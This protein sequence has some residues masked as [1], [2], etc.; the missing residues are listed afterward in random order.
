MKNILVPSLLVFALAACN[1]PAEPPAT[2]HE[3]EEP[4]SSEPTSHSLGAALETPPTLA[5][6]ASSAAI[7][8][9]GDDPA[10][11]LVLGATG[12]GGIEI[13]SLAGERLGT[14]A[15]RKA[16]LVDVHYNFPLSGQPRTLVVAFDP[17]T[18]EIV[19][20]TPG[21]DGNSLQLIAGE[22]IVTGTELEGLCLYRSP[23][24]GNFYAF[25][26]G[27]GYLQQW[28]L[29]ERDGAVAGRLIRNVPAGLG[30]AYCVVD[31]RS[32]TL[33]YSQE[34]VGVWRMNAEPESEAVPMAVDVANPFGRFE[35]DIKGISLYEQAD[36]SS[37]LLVSN[38]D[39]GLV[40]VYLGPDFE[41][42]GAF[43]IASGAIDGVEE[44]ENLGVAS[45]VRTSEFPGGVVIAV[46]EANEEG[47]SNFKLL[48]WQAIAD[49]HGLAV[50]AA[51]DPTQAT[52]PTATTVTASVETQPVAGFG[53]AADDPAIWVHP[54]QPEL[55]LII[56]TQKQRGLNIYAMDGSL[57]QT[58][59]DGRINNVDL[60]YG[61][62]LGDGQVDVITATNRT[63]ET[64]GIYAVDPETRNIYN[65][66]DGD[67]ATDM[68]DPYGLCMYRSAQTGAYYV[69][70]NDTDGRVKQW[71]LVDGGNQRIGAELVRDFEVGSQTEGCTADDEAG[72]LYIGEEDV[73]IWKYQAEPDAGTER[74]MVD[75]TE[76][77]NL[78]DDVEGLSI[79][80]GPNGSGYLLAS[81]QGADSYAVYERGG[82][83]RFLGIFHIIAD[84]QSGIDGASETDGLDVTSANLGPAFP[85]GVFVVQDGRNITPKERQNFKLVP[86]ERIAEAMNLEVHSGYDPRAQ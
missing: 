42:A 33:F 84:P 60:R 13:Y 80:Y 59:A 23:I 45:V 21:E 34:T 61:F 77:G 64:I 1:K 55:S 66:S 72:I 79:Y 24:S 43:S 65:I 63:T 22:P 6:E 15:D 50:T 57:L 11:S 28:E 19:S 81:N 86:W 39:T 51:L 31:D 53:D 7:V 17:A 26:A 40:H 37:F 32:S 12:G 5:G 47:G 73:G 85:N 30:A 3:V 18:S 48:S 27:D 58:I 10:S 2:T 8:I 46:D 14:Q 70:A 82:D 38:A 74:T 4:A 29:Y 20:Y 56:G 76:D 71:R 75:S 16:T 68:G 49:A 62:P 35:G 36:G 83:N 69:I 52:P 67:I 54:S 25:G 78:T 9:N 41:H 44:V